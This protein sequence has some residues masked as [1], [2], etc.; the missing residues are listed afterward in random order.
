ML[1]FAWMFRFLL[2]M[3]TM[4]PYTTGSWREFSFTGRN[5]V[6]KSSDNDVRHF[7]VSHSDIE[8]TAASLTVTLDSE[9]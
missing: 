1:V 7:H 8:Q 3:V 4:F 6:A 9:G 2:H 5:V